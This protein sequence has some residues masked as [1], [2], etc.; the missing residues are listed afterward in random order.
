MAIRMH[1]MLQ[2][3]TSLEKELQLIQRQEVTEAGT[4]AQPVSASS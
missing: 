3:F 1:E 4:K 2:R